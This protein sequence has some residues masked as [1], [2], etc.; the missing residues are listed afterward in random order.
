MRVL[1]TGGR[2]YENRAKV[3]EELDALHKEHTITFLMQGGATGADEWAKAWA[4]Q[5]NIEHKQY[6]ADWDN[7]DVNP[8]LIRSRKGKL[9][10]A[11]AGSTRNQIMLDEGKP[12]IVIAFPG[13]NGTWDMVKRAYAARRGSRPELQVIEIKEEGWRT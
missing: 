2:D 10:N 1:V 12:D 3:F 5:R 8:V 7:L 6:D 9:Y 11:L 13:G 4:I